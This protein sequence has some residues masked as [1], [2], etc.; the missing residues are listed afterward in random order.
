MVIA[1]HDLAR[2]D[3]L[4]AA[5]DSVRTQDAPSDLV[6]TVDHNPPLAEQ[7]A[8]AWPEVVVVQNR[9]DQGASGARNTGAER[10]QTPYLVF[11]DDD[12][13]ARPGWLSALLEAMDDDRLVGAGGAVEAA[14]S[15]PQPRWFPEEFAW[16]VGA[17]YQGMPTTPT[18]VRNVWSGNMIVRRDVF[19]QVGGF[20]LGFGKLGRR[21]RPEDTDLCIRMGH[22]VPGG[23]W[24]YVPDAV[25]DHHV[26]AVRATYRYFMVRV[27]NEGR[28]KIELSSLLGKQKVMPEERRYLTHVL[29]AGVGKGLATA[30]RGDLAG[31]L[32]AGAITSGAAAAGC[33]AVTA[34]GASLF[35]SR[36]KGA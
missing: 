9:Y 19:D 8:Q 11:L 32:R 31:L 35:T 2:W 13:A 3:Y 12:A 30:A 24:M 28:G 14:W 10:V 27:F 25:I 18:L 15:Q 7:V 1:T 21:S 6:V 29:P 4:E 36:R 5:V 34:L 26:P 22:A 33:G 16:G 23:R 20:R 17:S